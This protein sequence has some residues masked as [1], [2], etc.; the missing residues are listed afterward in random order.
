MVEGID[1]KDSP[2]MNPQDT[3]ADL[4]ARLGIRT[5]EVEGREETS[6]GTSGTSKRQLV[7]DIKKLTY[8][9]LSPTVINLT[10]Q[11]VRKNNTIT[12][13]ALEKITSMHYFNKVLKHRLMGFPSEVL[14]FD[15]Y[16]FWDWS[17]NIANLCNSFLP[18]FE[19]LVKREAFLFPFLDKPLQECASA[20]NSF[21]AFFQIQQ[22]TLQQKF[23]NLDETDV[24]FIGHSVKSADFNNPS[25]G[26]L[27]P[28]GSHVLLGDPLFETNE[29]KMMRLEIPAEPSGEQQPSWTITKWYVKPGD[30]LVL[31][32][33]IVQIT[34]MNLRADESRFKKLLQD[35]FRQL[36]RIRE[37][38]MML[39]DAIEEENRTGG[40]GASRGSTE[41]TSGFKPI[42]NRFRVLE[43]PSQDEI[44]T[45]SQELGMPEK[46]TGETM[47]KI[48]RARRR[49]TQ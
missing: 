23:L 12:A 21:M 48:R 36:S 31:G 39:K 13:S 18:V 2:S 6:E 4:Y 45:T 43:Q 8:K 34:A 32:S 9:G 16:R 40:S 26:I 30:A 41:E 3:Q 46:E 42:T 20:C 15:A 11:S 7:F 38:G 19:K 37:T 25:G 49:V 22:Q 17:A 28:L 44:K 35:I 29:S 10:K 27:A 14:V 24:D 33:R 5:E 1:L 47:K